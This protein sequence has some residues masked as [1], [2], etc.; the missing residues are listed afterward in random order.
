MTPHK[1][2]ILHAILPLIPFDGWSDYA[3]KEAARHAN[4]NDADLKAAFPHGVNDCVAFFYAEENRLL[5]EQLS[6]ALLAQKRV[7]ERIEMII[8]QQLG[9]WADKKEVIRRT[10]AHNAMLTN[11]PKSLQYLYDIIDGFW[12]L[13]GDTSSDFNFYTKRALLGK[14]YTSTLYVWLNDD[15]DNQETTEAFLYRRIEDV[16]KIEKTKAKVKG[17]MGKDMRKPA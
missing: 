6:P 8:L 13:A 11:T 2:Q 16:M 1:Q 10:L 9:N 5:A 3:L 12:R 14:V 15:S 7:P 4:I 17:W